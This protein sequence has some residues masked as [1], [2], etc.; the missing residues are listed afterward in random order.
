MTLLEGFLAYA[1]GAL[2]LVAGIRQWLLTSAPRDL[3]PPERP[4]D[5]TGWRRHGH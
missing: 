4:I 2:L 5:L 1:I 3:P